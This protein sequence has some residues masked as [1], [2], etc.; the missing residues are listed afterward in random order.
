MTRGLLWL[1]LTDEIQG[2]VRKPG[3][4]F[5]ATSRIFKLDLILPAASPCANQPA[6]VR[7][8]G[9]N[10]GQRTGQNLKGSPHPPAQHR[11]IWFPPSL[12][13]FIY[14]SNQRPRVASCHCLLVSTPN[15]SSSGAAGEAGP[16]AQ[17]GTVLCPWM[18]ARLSETAL[19]E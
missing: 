4:W 17:P 6:W 11:S 15:T 16:R 14:V 1:I 10:L 13:W 8:L 19:G 2:L 3:G 18:C 5:P 7:S 9:G 12:A